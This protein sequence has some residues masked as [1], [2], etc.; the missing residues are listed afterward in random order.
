VT[1]Q[2]VSLDEAKT[3][4]GLRMVV[5]P[6]APSPWSESAKGILHVKGLEW[7]P[8]KLDDRCEKLRDWSGHRSAPVVLFDGDPPRADW[9][10]ILMLT[11]RLAPS[12]SLLPTDPMDRACVLALSR[13]ICGEAGLG[14]SR[15]MQ[16]VH[17]GMNDE[18]GF[19]VRVARYL[20][21]KYGYCPDMGATS[22]S[23][24]AGLLRILASRLEAQRNAGSDYYVGDA[25]SAADIYSASFMAMFKPLPCELCNMR[26]DIRGAFET[27]DPVTQAALNPILFEHRDAVYHRHLAL[28]LSL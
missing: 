16:L 7:A 13:E 1:L 22:G 10:E 11:E 5:V 12:V 17:A 15:R 9:T 20:A 14:W 4:S 3:R 28:P 21:R 23:R 27:T 6:D 26:E 8:V 25:L 19:P 2:Y 18:G 24:V